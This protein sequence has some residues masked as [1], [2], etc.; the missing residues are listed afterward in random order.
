MTITPRRFSVCSAA[1][2]VLFFTPSAR[3]QVFTNLHN[4]LFTNGVGP[5]ASLIISGNT[6]YGT[7]RNYGSLDLPG[8]GYG[9]VF[10]MNTDGS[11]FTNLHTFSGIVPDGGNLNASLVLSGNTLYTTATFGG[12]SDYGCVIAINTDGTG[13][14]NLHNF[15]APLGPFPSTNYDGADP[16]TSLILS[17]GTL[18]G[19][20]NGGGLNG[21]G[22]LFA[23]STNGTAFTNLHNFNIIDGQNPGSDLVLSG[24]TFYGATAAGGAFHSGTIFKVSTNGS[25][26]TNLF[27]FPAASGP[28]NTNAEGVFPSCGL[29]LAGTNLYGTASE[30]GELGGGT[31][32]VLDTNGTTFNVLH[33]FATTNGPTGINA[34]GA[35]PRS[36]LAL[37]G[38]VL[39]GTT[40]TGGSSGSGTIFKINTDGTGFS[41]L[42]EFS[43][44]NGVGSTGI[45]GTN[46]DG[47][48]PVGALLFSGDTLYG[49]ASEGGT[50][51]NGTIFSIILP[52]TLAIHL[53][54]TNAI[55]TWPS[56]SAGFNLEMSTNP[57]GAWNPLSGQYSVT[58][59]ISGKQKFYRLHSQ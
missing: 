56:N 5:V 23:L 59:P 21:W 58:N 37:S 53:S 36:G 35:R 12:A 22:T 9:T 51:G 4:L 31:I 47:A 25:A 16:S 10:R 57:A 27:H 17:G 11:G 33:S 30:G 2:A 1:L 19:L 3:A 42:Y 29:V 32:F 38:N 13:L 24:S 26:Y 45:G 54:G 7:A 44:T 39:Y 52:P 15:S 8:D 40:F 55:L 41:T 20:A 14:T 48:H 34:G 49:T 6:L 46:L 43:A 28:N 18:Y 50:L